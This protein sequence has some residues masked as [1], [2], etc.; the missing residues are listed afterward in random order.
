[1]TLFTLSS[2]Y[3]SIAPV[4]YYFF[5]L[6]FQAVGIFFILLFSDRVTSD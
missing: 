4:L 2:F 1:V 3:F 6:R 5:S